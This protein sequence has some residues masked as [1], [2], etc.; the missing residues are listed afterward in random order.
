MHLNQGCKWVC[1]CSFP[2]QNKKKFLLMEV[3][4]QDDNYIL[5]HI[6][7]MV[8]HAPHVG[9][10]IFYAIYS[11]SCLKQGIFCILFS[12]SQINL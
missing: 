9:L 1:Q 3:N 10:R 8:E 2:L 7:G 4:S 11:N 5:R 6:A 12:Q